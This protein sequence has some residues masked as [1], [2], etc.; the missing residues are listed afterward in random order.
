MQHVVLYIAHCYEIPVPAFGELPDIIDEEFSNV[1]K[2]EDEVVLHDSLPYH[3]SQR[4]LNDPVRDL[5]LPK[6]SAELLAQ[7]LKERNFLSDSVCITFRNR[8]Q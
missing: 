8:L 2:N 6:Y 7:G 3:H 5:N 1:D 4:E